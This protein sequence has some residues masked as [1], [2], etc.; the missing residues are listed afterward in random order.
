MAL[1]SLSIL[2]QNTNVDT[3]M[4]YKSLQI[5]R[6]GKLLKSVQYTLYQLGYNSL[7]RCMKNNII[8]LC[9]IQTKLCSFCRE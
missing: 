2:R 4:F 5:R 6:E 1:Q 3:S 9:L 7:R 8:K